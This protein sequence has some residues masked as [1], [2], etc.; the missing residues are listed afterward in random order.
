MSEEHPEVEG[1]SHAENYPDDEI[2]KMLDAGTETVLVRIVEWTE[3]IPG[4]RSGEAP[5]LVMNQGVTGFETGK[6]ERLLEV[7]VTGTGRTRNVRVNKLGED[8]QDVVQY[9]LYA[10]QAVLAQNVSTQTFETLME[11]Q[12]P[13]AEHADGKQIIVTKQMPHNPPPLPPKKQRRKR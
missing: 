11:A 5:S 12:R 13:P 2:D 6:T 7:A 8:D 10:F 4:E 3:W 1:G 9:S